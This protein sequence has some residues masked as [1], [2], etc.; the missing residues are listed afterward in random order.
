[1]DPSV[2]FYHPC[3]PDP[4]TPARRHLS[5]LKASILVKGKDMVMQLVEQMK[6]KSA[7]AAPAKDKKKAAKAMKIRELAEVSGTFL[8]IPILRMAS[9]VLYWGSASSR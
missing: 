5:L 3:H 7:E 2:L 4:W 9:M 1:M 8:R 6:A